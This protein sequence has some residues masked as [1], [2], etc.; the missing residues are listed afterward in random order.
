MTQRYCQLTLH[1]WQAKAA[2]PRSPC[3]PPGASPPRRSHR[4]CTAAGGTAIARRKTC[5]SKKK[6]YYTGTICTRASIRY[7]VGCASTSPPLEDQGPRGEVK[8]RHVR[9]YIK[10]RANKLFPNKG[11]EHCLLLW[12]AILGLEIHNKSGES[13]S[14]HLLGLLPDGFQN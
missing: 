6:C 5:M 10:C 8:A 11:Q 1:M 13:S 7:A 12:G 14:D 2:A 4:R 3:S 9:K